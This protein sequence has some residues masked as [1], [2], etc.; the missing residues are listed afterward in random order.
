MQTKI[1]PILTV[2]RNSSGHITR[3]TG[4]AQFAFELLS[5]QLNFTYNNMKNVMRIIF[6][7]NYFNRYG[8]LQN[9]VPTISDSPTFGK[10]AMSYIVQGVSI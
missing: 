3:L 7:I 1:S 10:G 4:V 8:V 2:E 9:H 5:E 6:K